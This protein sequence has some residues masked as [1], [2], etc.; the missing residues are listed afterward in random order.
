MLLIK[1][2]KSRTAPL[3]IKAAVYWPLCLFARVLQ[4]IHSW[5]VKFVLRVASHKR[6]WFKLEL[7]K[8]DCHESTWLLGKYFMWAT[9]M[10]HVTVSCSA[11]NF[12]LSFGLVWHFGDIHPPRWLIMTLVIIGSTGLMFEVLSEMCQQCWMCCHEM[13]CTHSYPSQD[14]EYLP[15]INMLPLWA[16]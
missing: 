9:S 12:S 13:W 7:K 16:C 2:W 3:L 8:K 6:F 15:N 10:T 11:H 4:I 14:G 1:N 5:Y